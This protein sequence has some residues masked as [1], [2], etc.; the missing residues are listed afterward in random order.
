M[1]A[2]SSRTRRLAALGSAPLA[3]MVAGLLVWQGS[4]AAFTAS[5]RNA[6]NEW[7]TGSVALSDDDLGRAGFNVTNLTPGDTGEKCIVVTATTNVPGTVRGYVENLDKSAQGLEN[8][9]RFS[10]QQGTGGS[11]NDCSGFV[12]GP[13]NP[14]GP[15]SLTTLSTVNNNFANGGTPWH[16]AGTGTETKTYK[17]TWTFDASTL[18]QTQIDALQGAKTSIDLVWEL[19]ND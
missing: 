9:I 14:V 12:P 18:S 2:P 17:G 10:V 13:P 5:T 11:F 7:S 15:Q 3:I 19:Q 1:H 6:G 16:V 4:T 8:Y